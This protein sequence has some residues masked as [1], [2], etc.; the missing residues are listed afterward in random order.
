MATRIVPGHWGRTAAGAAVLASLAAPGAATD[1]RLR[2]EPPAQVQ[3]APSDPYA[4]FRA[5]VQRLD[6]KQRDSLKR[7]LQALRSKA[8]PQE[9]ERYAKMLQIL[10]E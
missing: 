6:A 5:Q 2:Y 10:G 8:N 7:E 9:A 4:A 1:F 3:T